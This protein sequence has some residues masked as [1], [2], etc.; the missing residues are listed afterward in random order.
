MIIHA[1][2]LGSL[3]TDVTSLKLAAVSFTGG[4]A[5]I[6]VILLVNAVVDAMTAALRPLACRR[7]AGCGR[8][9]DPNVL[10]GAWAPC[11]RAALPRAPW[12]AG[13]V[14]AASVGAESDLE[15]LGPPGTPQSLAE[16]ATQPGW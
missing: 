13:G 1:G 8:L 3:S 10:W 2:V 9:H 11:S 7:K 15:R 16:Y 12:A 6:T 14:G 4:I 5:L